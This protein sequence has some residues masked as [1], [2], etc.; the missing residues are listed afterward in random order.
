MNNDNISGNKV[1]D[2]DGMKEDYNPD[3]PLEMDEAD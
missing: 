2:G 3:N 1:D